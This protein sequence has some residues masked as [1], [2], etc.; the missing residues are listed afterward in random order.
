[1]EAVVLLENVDDDE[2]DALSNP[3]RSAFL[4][5]WTD[6]GTAQLNTAHGAAAAAT[7]LSP[8]KGGITHG[9]AQPSTCL[10]PPID[11]TGE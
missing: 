4:E 7:E 11:S 8:G 10:V 2:E 1:M 6:V 9:Q 3:L 5:V